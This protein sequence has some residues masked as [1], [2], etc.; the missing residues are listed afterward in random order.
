[1][2]RRISGPALVIEAFEEFWPSLRA[3]SLPPPPS[4]TSPF[5]SAFDVSRRRVALSAVASQASPPRLILSAQ[6]AHSCGLHPQHDSR[7][8]FTQTCR[9]LPVQGPGA[10]REWR[11][12]QGCRWGSSGKKRRNC[13]GFIKAPGSTVKLFIGGYI[14]QCAIFAESEEWNLNLL[15]KI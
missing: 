13:A 5:S 9:P 15:D 1:M 4:T 2:Q 3:H 7:Q 10:Q 6:A 14:S 8:L 12:G 11:H